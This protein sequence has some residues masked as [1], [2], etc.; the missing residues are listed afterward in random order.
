[1][2]DLESLKRESGLSSEEIS[3]LED[4]VREEFKGDNMMFELHLLRILKALKEGWIT[5]EEAMS[6]EV[7]I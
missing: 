3:R 5:L 4:R 2:F 7:A 1:M 6:E